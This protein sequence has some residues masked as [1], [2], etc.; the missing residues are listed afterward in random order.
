[1]CPGFSRESTR[2]L[3][4]Q[5]SCRQVKAR[6]SSPRPQFRVTSLS[7]R[8]RRAAGSRKM[9]LSVNLHRDVQLVG[10]IRVYMAR[11]CT[12]GAGE[13]GPAVVEI[14]CKKKSSANEEISKL[15]RELSLTIPGSIIA[16]LKRGYYKSCALADRSRA[17]ARS[18][19]DIF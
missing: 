16:G 15:R 18:A 8:R 9:Y 12:A 11:L 1:M 5:E 19:V 4:P 17:I 13:M 7:S 3:R 6:T 2:S 10:T 14:R